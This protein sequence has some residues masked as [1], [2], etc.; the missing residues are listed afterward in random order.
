M[1]Q[2]VNAYAS[3]RRSHR[4]PNPAAAAAAATAAALVRVR[5]CA[6]CVHATCPP[7]KMLRVNLP[8]VRLKAESVLGQKHLLP[9]VANAQSCVGMRP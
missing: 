4:A 8:C 7:F 2:A 1:A 9:A 3:S 5:R 6:C